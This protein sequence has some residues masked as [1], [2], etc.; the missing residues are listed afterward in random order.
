VPALLSTEDRDQEETSDGDLRFEN[1]RALMVR[2][3][4]V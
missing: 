4:E 1:E 3:E 2:K